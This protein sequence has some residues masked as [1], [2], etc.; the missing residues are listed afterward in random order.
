[1]RR[2]TA[3]LLALMLVILAGCGAPA[4]DFSGM[5][6]A[7]ILDQDH[8][9]V[10]EPIRWVKYGSD[11]TYSIQAEVG[12]EILYTDYENY[13]LQQ[14][15]NT[16]LLTLHDITV[17]VRVSLQVQKAQ[18]VICYHACG[19]TLTHSDDD[20]YYE[21][22]DLT[23]RKRANTALGTDKLI[24]DGYT[25]VGWNTRPDMTGITIGLG[26]RVT[27]PEDTN[28]LDLYAQWIPWDDAED[29][30]WI[31]HGSHMEL[32]GY[33]GNADTVAVPGIIGGLPVTVIGT[34]CFTDCSA[35][36]VIL[37]NTVQTVS[38]EAFQNCALREL[39][40]FDNLMEIH[41]ESFVACPDFSTVRI[42]ASHLPCYANRSRHSHYAD[43]IDMLILSMDADKPRMVFFSGSSMWFSLDGCQVDDFFEQSFIPVNIALNG[44][45]S[46]T[47]QFEVLKNYLRPGDV[48]IHAPEACST[49]QLLTKDIMTQNM[50][51]CL[52]LN[53]D[54]LAGVD[55]RNMSQVFTAF[56]EYNA[57]RQ[58]LPQT[59]YDARED[60]RWIDQY[61]C[62]PFTRPAVNGN[63]DLLDDSYIG[64]DLVTDASLSRLNGYYSQIA[65]ITENPVLFAFAPINYD[66][67]PPEDRDIAVWQQF[68][69]IFREGLCDDALIITSMEESVFRGSSFYYTDFHLNSEA[70]AIHTQNLCEG[71]QAALEEVDAP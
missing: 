43:K 13:T 12:Y 45:Y 21:N 6:C 68:E 54:L 16:Y 55:I 36:T 31:N 48:F 49:Y 59:P 5:I 34:G 66:G 33:H 26:S 9:S 2:Y 62:I 46:G 61:G 25:L 63:E 56:T 58:D 4:P 69:N 50:F 3:I 40:F 22:Y 51:T 67:L 20:C 57:V 7:V 18:A 24:Y 37:P 1:M 38:P 42:N 15:N 64:I 52:E 53:Y 11:A 10:Q 29:F 30:S 14:E 35:V 27:V 41:D 39:L 17:P 60:T 32:T 28:Y 65:G 44:F 19:G 47:A 8:L 23:Y 71:I 70:T